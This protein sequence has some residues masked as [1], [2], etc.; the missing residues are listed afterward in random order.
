M[1]GLAPAGESLLLARKSNQKA[2][3]MRGHAAELSFE[4][5]GLSVRA[6][7][8]S[9][10]LNKRCV[11]ALR[12]A[13]ACISRLREMPKRKPRD[14]LNFRATTKPISVAMLAPPLLHRRVQQRP[15]QLLV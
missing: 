1:P 3:G 9:Q 8:A 7:A 11:T 13:R 10:R 5:G 4:P 12:V 15:P 2:L 6:T 14:E